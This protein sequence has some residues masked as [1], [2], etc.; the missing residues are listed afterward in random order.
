MQKVQ[1]IVSE[2]SL[3]LDKTGSNGVDGRGGEL[4]VKMG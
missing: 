2:L 3:K 4:K 1:K